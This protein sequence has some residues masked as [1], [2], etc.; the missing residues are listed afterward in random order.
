MYYMR[1]I[2][3]T[4][5]TSINAIAIQQVQMMVKTLEALTHILNHCAMH[6][7]VVVRYV[8]SGMV[9]YIHLGAP[10]ITR[11]KVRS[12]AGGHFFLSKQSMD[13]TKLP[14]GPVPLN[15]PIHTVYKV[16]CNMMASTANAEIGMLY[17][18]TRKGEEMRLALA[19]TGH[20]QPPYT[21]SH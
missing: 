8:A 3:P 5:I 1:V 13:P 2:D 20:P 9:L 15:G 18:N 17:S 12:R 19:E 14:T 4:M 6:P 16:I 7:D 10:F 21:C 11:T